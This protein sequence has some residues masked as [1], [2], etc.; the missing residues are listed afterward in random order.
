MNKIISLV[1]AMVMMCTVLGALAEGQLAP[2]YA[3]VGDAL[4]DSAEGR[5]V[6]GGEG[7]YYA[8]VTKKDGKY[9]RSVAYYDETM[10]ELQEASNSLDFEAEDF[11]EKLE[12]AMNAA[13]A[14]LKTLP[15][16]YSEEFT[17]VPL[18]S[19]EMEA[20]VG[21]TLAQLTE[22]GFE[23]GSNGTE[24]GEGENEMIIV[25]SLRYGV[26]DYFCEVDTDFDHYIDAQENGTEGGLVVK[27]MTLAGITEW[28]F[29]KRFHTDG[30]VE[31]PEDPFAAFGEIMTEIMTVVE[32]I[33]NG[34]EVDIE[35]FTAT[36][37]EKYPDYADMIDMY[38][39]LFQTYGAE[40][41]AS[42]MTTAE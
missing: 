35:S 10:S 23:I 12:A 26:F 29:E 1:M 27:S 15:I 38:V 34:E 6:A 18:T 40:D 11:F 25:Y 36:L 3:T 41:F 39:V 24:P 5:V 13:D 37:K 19:E 9:Y 31:E 2:L 42:M 14:Y 16:A 21:K 17:A 22:E 32:K 20:K 28:G 7:D 8:V 30:T 4:E 33:Q